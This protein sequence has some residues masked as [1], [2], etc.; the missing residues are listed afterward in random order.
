M[1]VVQGFSSF[2]LPNLMIFQS[3]E[4]RTLKNY[5]ICIPKIWQKMKKILVQ[6]ALNQLIGTLISDTCSETSLGEGFVN[7][8][9]FNFTVIHFYAFKRHRNDP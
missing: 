3:G 7:V 1:Q 2:F 6:L 9:Y 5:Q 8:K 4:C